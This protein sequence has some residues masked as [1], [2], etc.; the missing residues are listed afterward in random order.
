MI[1]TSTLE[2]R[3]PDRRRRDRDRL[4]RVSGILFAC[5]PLGIARYGSVGEYDR[6][7]AA[8]AAC[9]RAGELHGY[10]ATHGLECLSA[11]RSLEHFLRL[12]P[13]LDELYPPGPGE[14][15][16]HG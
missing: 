14:S 5:D 7:A 13:P 10:L 2:S 11:V 6:H 9:T 8:I 4:M 12:D 15:P 1:A 3:H 16:R